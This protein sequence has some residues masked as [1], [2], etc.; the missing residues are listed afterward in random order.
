MSASINL[1]ARIFRAQ[2]KKRSIA[3]SFTAVHLQIYYERGADLHGHGESSL[4][5]YAESEL[6]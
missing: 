5:P 1:I 4:R 3:G 6:G 2:I